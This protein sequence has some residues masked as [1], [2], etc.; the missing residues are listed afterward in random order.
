MFRIASFCNNIYDSF[1]FFEI[2][3]AGHVGRISKG[4]FS[5]HFYRRLLVPP[6][7]RKIAVFKEWKYLGFSDNFCR[8][9]CKNNSGYCFGRFP[10]CSGGETRDSFT[11]KVR[12]SGF[13]AKLLATARFFSG[14][15]T[16]RFFQNNSTSLFFYGKFVRSRFGSRNS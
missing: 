6:I 11:I 16:C 2:T 12:W 5:K 7:P 8:R 10:P 4:V 13:F 9:Y 15:P 3:T 14:I 1:N